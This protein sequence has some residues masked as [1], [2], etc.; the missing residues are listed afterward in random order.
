MTTIP[1]LL[2]AF[3][4]L[5]ASPLNNRLDMS[6]VLEILAIDILGVLFQLF[7]SNVPQ[8]PVSREVDTKDKDSCDLVV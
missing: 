2:A 4:L 3:W 8:L 6:I 1:A 7:M 5:D